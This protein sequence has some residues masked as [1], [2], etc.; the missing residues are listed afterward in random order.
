MNDE[1]E[2]QLSIKKSKDKQESDFRKWL[3]KNRPKDSV[4]YPIE[5]NSTVGIPDIFCCYNKH[6]CWIECKT[7]LTGAS[8]I[9][10][11]QLLFMQ[12][13]YKQGGFVKVAV[14]RLNTKTYKPSSIHIYDFKDIVQRP[15][16]SFTVSG[17]DLLFP[18]D[19]KPYWIW[20]Y[21]NKDDTLADLY[22]HLLLDPEEFTY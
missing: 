13:L 18:S 1:K 15:L 22:Q 6:S 19:L 10:G 9:R 14:Q 20:N 16:Q 12:N 17:T 11:S 2:L 3:I 21:R 4:M 8:R 7:L 5:T